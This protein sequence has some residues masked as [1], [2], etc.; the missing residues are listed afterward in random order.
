KFF[1]FFLWLLVIVAIFTILDTLVHAFFEPLEIYYYPIPNA[2]KFIS[3]SYLFWYAVGKLVGTTIM[4]SI[5]FFLIKR[6]KNLR[7]KVLTFTIIIVILIEIRY[8]LSG[9]YSTRWDLYNMIN[10]FIML[11]IPAYVV[12]KKTNCV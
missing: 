9:D 3:T 6:I 10:H 1:T 5:L 8:M 2:F 4:G 11:Y 7:A 12:F